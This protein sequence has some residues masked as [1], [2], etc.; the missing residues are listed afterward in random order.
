MTDQ[1]TDNGNIIKSSYI[2]DTVQRFLRHKL[3]MAALCFLLIQVI[4][5][6]AL[7]ITMGLDPYTSAA[8]GFR[9]PPSAEHLLGTDTVGRDVLARL[10]A[11]AQTSLFVG[12]ISSLISFSIGV[13]L[14]LL[15]G[16]FRGWIEV[17]VMRL[18]DIAMSFPSIILI[19]V[20]VS[21]VGPSINSVAVIIGVMSWPVF[22]KLLFSNVISV[23]EKDYVEAARAAGAR[24]FTIILKFILPNSF[25]PILVAFTFRMAEAIIQE[26][27]LSF[28]W[29]GVQPPSASLGNILHAAQSVAILTRN[30]WMW[31][32]AGVVLVLTIM[33]INFLGDGIRDALDPKMKI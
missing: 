24:N 33:S 26:S 31:I 10:I 15:A 28:L 29:L 18:A 5:I 32:P 8:G 1:M 6:I 16:Y 2:R 25:A 11:G 21:V 17:V 23:R 22:A 3:A 9:A 27:T 14:G 30:P 12:L 4:L 19:L 7:P 13:P 20:L